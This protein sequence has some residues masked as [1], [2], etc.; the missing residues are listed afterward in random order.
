MP[1]RLGTAALHASS[2]LVYL[3]SDCFGAGKQ[4]EACWQRLP[5][6]ALMGRGVGSLLG[7]AIGLL[8][9]TG[10]QELEKR[11]SPPPPLISYVLLLRK[12]PSSTD[13]IV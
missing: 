1:Q 4:Q 13:G 10:R 7:Q 3:I 6:S 11:R 5:D 8:P 12:L 2:T 9:A